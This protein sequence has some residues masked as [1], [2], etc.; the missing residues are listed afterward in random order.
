MKPPAGISLLV[1]SGLGAWFVAA[2]ANLYWFSAPWADT[3]CYLGPAA[4]SPSVFR[5]TA[6]LLGG[7]SGSDHVWGLHFPGA[8]LLYSVVFSLVKFRPSVGVLVFIFLWIALAACTGW[9]VLRLTGQYFWAVA[10]GALVLSDRSQFAVAQAQRPELA[11]SLVLLILLMVLAGVPPLRGRSRT[12]CAVLGFF[13]LPLLHPVTFAAGAC[14]CLFLGWQAKRDDHPDLRILGASCLGYAG[15]VLTFFLWF[16]LQ[17]DAWS[18]FSDHASTLKIPYT[19]GGTFWRALQQFYYPTLT[20]HLMWGAALILSV[21]ILYAWLRRRPESDPALVWAAAIA[22]SCLII[23]QKFDNRSYLALYLPE[24]VVITIVSLFKLQ[25]KAAGP[26]S[27]ARVRTM[28]CLFIAAHGLFWATRTTKFLQSG[29]PHIRSELSRI[30]WGLP[31][32]GHVL[33]PEAFW[34]AALHDPSRFAL[35]TLPQNSSRERRT[36]YE[37][38]AYGGLSSGDIVVVDRFQL[39]QPLRT[40][41]PRDWTLVE[42]LRHIL[43]GRLEWGYDLAVWR[44]N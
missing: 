1:L 35:N 29:S 12:P 34:E 6:P 4:A 24:A 41:G 23:Q 15:G 37:T 32:S 3:W 21:T 20:G 19:Y 39:N 42:N 11:G 9:L 16:Y 25:E 44:K 30:A 13:L 22:L 2:W 8:P 18:Q 17:P 7:F 40:F 10:A 33:V 31:K 27:R 28:V 26:R 36:A 14:L 43:P 5:I 38:L